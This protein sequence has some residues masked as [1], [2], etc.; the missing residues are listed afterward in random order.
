[1]N[2]YFESKGF[3][4][5][6]TY[7]CQHNS[8]DFIITKNNIHTHG[9]YKWPQSQKDFMDK[10]I[11]DFEKE[12][13]KE[14]IPW[15][16][17]D[18]MTSILP[19]KSVYISSQP[20]FR[21]SVFDKLMNEEVSRYIANDVINTWNLWEKRNSIF[22]GGLKMKIKNVIFNDPATIVFWTDGTKTVVK[23]Q[24]GDI[25][26]P[27]MGLAMAISKK[28]LGN[29][30]NY[31]NEFKKWLPETEIEKEAFLYD[32]KLPDTSTIAKAAEAMCNFGKTV[33]E[34]NKKSTIRKAYDILAKVQN[35]R[36]LP[37]RGLDEA[38]RYLSD[39]LED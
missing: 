28:A 15:E 38:M 32:I 19:P 26:N 31:C 39:A 36:L 7:D 17:P 4:V 29:K 6:R 3:E 27:E 33:R 13:A 14:R 11:R 16:N 2:A 25:F 21:G 30:G 24:D 9:I 22:S 10:M 5:K 35:E 1:M 23:C 20:A 12:F 37:I 34:L 8:Y 18:V